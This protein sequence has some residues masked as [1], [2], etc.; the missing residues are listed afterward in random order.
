MV[1]TSA[2]VHNSM[3]TCTFTPENVWPF[4]VTY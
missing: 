3:T 4:Q 2:E 1:Q